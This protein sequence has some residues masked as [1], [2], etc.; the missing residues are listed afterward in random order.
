MDL[1]DRTSPTQPPAGLA[2]GRELHF[3]I[4]GSR[5][6]TPSMP[7]RAPSL[8]LDPNLP[9][10]VATRRVC[11]GQINTAIYGLRHEPDR[12]RGVHEARKATKRMRAMLRLVRDAVGYDVYRMENVVLRDVSRVLSEAR[13]AAVIADLAEMVLAELG[14]AIDA[15][16]RTQ[17]TVELD[18]RRA[19]A[20]EIV[21]DRQ[22]MMGLA[23]TLLTSRARFSKWPIDATATE[24]HPIPNTFDAIEPGIRRVYRRGR[25]A[26]RLAETEPSPHTFHMWRKRAKYLR[27]QMEAI[28]RWWPPV[29]DA[30]VEALEVLG[31]SLGDEHD[32]SELADVVRAEPTL[33][34]DDDGRRLFLVAVARRRVELQHEA[35]AIGHRLYR[36]RPRD[37]TDRLRTYWDHRIRR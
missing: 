7:L 11:L 24:R 33:L 34:P 21:H 27:Y 35:L 28:H 6:S 22:V 32:L 25:R 5:A 26:M 2:A 8:E 13:S 15:D 17:L 36:E 12:E 10:A 16:A 18:R 23:T 3:V 14:G 1:L 20:A 4:T 37:F 29:L 19:K 9:L 30:T 31:E